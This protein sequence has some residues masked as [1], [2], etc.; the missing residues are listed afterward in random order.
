MMI[1]TTRGEPKGTQDHHHHGER[2]AKLPKR[3]QDYLIQLLAKAG[4]VQNHRPGLH[5]VSNLALCRLLDG[6]LCHKTPLRALKRRQLNRIAKR[7]GVRTCRKKSRLIVQE[8]MAIAKDLYLAKK[9]KRRASY[10]NS[11]NDLITGTPSERTPKRVRHVR[12]KAGSLANEILRVLS[13]SRMP[14]R[15]QDIL[16]HVIPPTDGA[17]KAD[18]RSIATNCT[19]LYREGFVARTGRTGLNAYTILPFGRHR[20]EGGAVSATHARIAEDAL[21]YAL[22]S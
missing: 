11:A 22:K 17:W 2:D 6:D 18:R 16:E 7:H 14:M 3:T 4:V 12:R 1:A 21:M 15:L 10:Y 13:V 20:L 19:R 8:L 9:E 5:N